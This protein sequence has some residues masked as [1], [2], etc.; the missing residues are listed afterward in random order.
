MSFIKKLTAVFLALCL[1]FAYAC[2]TGGDTTA[3]NTDLSGVGD[4]S[5]TGNTDKP[6]D[7]TDQGSTSDPAQPENPTDPTDPVQPEPPTDP[8]QPEPPTEPTPPEIVPV[9]LDGAQLSGEYPNTY[10]VPNTYIEEMQSQDIQL[11]GDYLLVSNY[12]VRD[13]GNTYVLRMISLEDG[14]LAAEIAIPSSGFMTLQVNETN[15]GIVDPDMEKIRI[16]D[17]MLNLVSEYDVDK[18]PDDFSIYLSRDMH[19]VY[20][21]GWEKGISVTNI[22]TMQTTDVLTNITEVYVRNQAYE[23]VIISYVD[24]STQRRT[25][26]RL[27]LESGEIEKLPTTKDTISAQTYNGAWLVS[28]GSTWGKFI[29]TRN[30]EKSY[31]DWSE[32]RVELLSPTG[33]LMTM[34]GDGKSMMLYDMDGAFVSKCTVD[35]S[36]NGYIG[37]NILW[38]DMYGGYFFLCFDGRGS[39]KLYFWDPAIEVDGEALSMRAEAESAVGKTAPKE[40]YDRAAAIGEKYGIKINIADLCRYDY[41]YFTSY[42]VNDPVFINEALDVIDAALSKYPEGFLDQ[43]RFDNINAIEFE[44][45]GGLRSTDTDVYSEIYSALATRDNDVYHIVFDLYIIREKTVFHELCHLIDAKLEYDA[46]LRPEALFSEEK[47]MELQ[48]EGFVYPETYGVLP[49][50]VWQ[51]V[52]SGYFID[53][54]SCRSPGE[55]RARMMENAM[56]GNTVEFEH[57]QGLT[58]KLEYYCQCIRDAFDTQNWPQTT[59]WE[60][61]LG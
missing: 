31:F 18:H 47:W 7:V 35:E 50:Y 49:Q 29:L 27:N 60:Q 24:L 13:R 32:N 20:H 54:Y 26:S 36:E 57:R 4:A 12:E 52:N 17:N 22:D 33:H 25:A 10:Y 58:A 48:P 39:G 11:Y 42:A 9:L 8:V 5:D 56:L 59:Q 14:S 45:V 55:D 43:L 6:A 46:S 21:I 38:S 3:D 41:S 1:L 2:G 19:N 61:I 44:L 16:Y 15:I 40:C 53:D 34:T 30:G 23:H 28:D 51:Y 37:S